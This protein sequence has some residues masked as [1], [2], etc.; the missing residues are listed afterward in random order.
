MNLDL[1]LARLSAYDIRLFSFSGTTFTALSLLQL[2]FAVVLLF[3]AAGT[4]KRWMV[5]RVLVRFQM[6]LGTRQAIG[7]IVRYLVLIIG[8]VVILQ[9]A[10]INL[11]AFNVVAGALGVGVGFGLQ[12]VFSNFISGLIIMF[13]RPIKVGDRIELTNIEGVVHDIGARRT[14]VVT[15]DNVTILVP[16][17]RFIIDNVV[18]LVYLASPVRLRVPVNVA[19]AS[20][21]TLVRQ[22]LLEAA[23]DNSQVMAEPP[24]SVFLLSL[25]GGAMSFELLVWYQPRECTRQLLTSE[26]NFGIGAKLRAHG[27]NNA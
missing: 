27:I 18:N 22:L 6:D 11:T 9:T 26:L 3:F 25:G 20:D 7:S 8:F 4:L 12:N 1:W 24:P 10:G 13:E 15:N 23:A 19:G 21:I 2:A 5:A 17:Q 14:T 16:N